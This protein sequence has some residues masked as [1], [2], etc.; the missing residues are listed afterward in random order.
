[1]DQA[2]RIEA[3]VLAVERAVGGRD[4][5]L[6]GVVR[7]TVVDTLASHVLVPCF[8]ALQ[9]G[10]PEVSLELVADVRHLSLSMREADIAVRLPPFKG[11]DLVVQP[12]GALPYR[13]YASPAYLER[14]GEPDFAP[15]LAGHRL[16]AGLDGPEAPQLAGWLADIGPRANVALKGRTA[17]RH[18]SKRRF[19]ARASHAW[20]ACAAMPWARVCGGSNRRRRGPP[21][22]GF[23]SL[24]TRTTGRCHG[25]AWCWTR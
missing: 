4:A 9:F 14:H 7:V 17:R 16:V 21:G 25:S 2:E 6:E 20:R 13:L 24:C 3:E 5:Q 15:G 11:H 8:A 10:S 18:S 1:M 12:V 22:S 19:G 23:G